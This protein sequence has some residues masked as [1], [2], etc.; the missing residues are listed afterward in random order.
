MR[1]SSFKQ[2]KIG[3]FFNSEDVSMASDVLSVPGSTIDI[4]TRNPVILNYLWAAVS[5]GL[6]VRC[7]DV[8]RVMNSGND[9]N[10]V[11]KCSHS[12]T[13]KGLRNLRSAER[14]INSHI[15]FG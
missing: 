3:I 7:T 6:E 2:A 1:F 11:L 10:S 5:V 4:E 8:T 13:N 12:R 14:S 9:S 15:R